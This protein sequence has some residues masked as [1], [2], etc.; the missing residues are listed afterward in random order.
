MSYSNDCRT[1][2]TFLSIV[3]EWQNKLYLLNSHP[4]APVPAPKQAL[5]Q[6]GRRT[7]ET[8]RLWNTFSAWY[9]WWRLVIMKLRV[10]LRITNLTA[11]HVG[12]QLFQ[13]SAWYVM[14][15]YSCFVST[16]L[17]L[18]QH[19]CLCISKQYCCWKCKSS[20]GVNSTAPI[21]VFV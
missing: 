6:K 7:K 5:S 10:T 8:H 18:Y 3:Q 20:L 16:I 15:M 14:L 17:C 19:F 11:E 9:K 21:H 1:M 13:M 4:S 2:L 12:L